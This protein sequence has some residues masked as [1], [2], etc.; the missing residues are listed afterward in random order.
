MKDQNLYKLSFEVNSGSRSSSSWRWVLNFGSEAGC[1][2]GSGIFF[3]KFTT[4]GP[5]MSYRAEKWNW[6][7]TGTGQ[8]W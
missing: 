4:N 5:G 2:Y 6:P 1:S 3:S 8:D 7:K